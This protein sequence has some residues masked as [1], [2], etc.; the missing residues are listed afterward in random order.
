MSLE[1]CGDVV[2][3]YV[4]AFVYIHESGLEEVPAEAPPT[5]AGGKQP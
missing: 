3:I 4:N 1:A 5:N 2:F